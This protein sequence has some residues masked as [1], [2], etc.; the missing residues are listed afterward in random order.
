MTDVAGKMDK[1]MVEV[2]KELDEKLANFGWNKDVA[3]QRS[4]EEMLRRQGNNSAGSIGMEIRDDIK[5]AK[6][7]DLFRD[8]K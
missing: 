7:I 3:G 8:I 6:N 2:E 5:D 4:I 1:Q